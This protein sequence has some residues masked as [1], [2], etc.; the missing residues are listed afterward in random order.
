MLIM[1]RTFNM[2]NQ[3]KESEREIDLRKHRDRDW[4][5]KHQVWAL[6]NGKGLQMNASHDEKGE[7]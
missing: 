2:K 6:N 5:S 3:D 7:N 4:L 1:V